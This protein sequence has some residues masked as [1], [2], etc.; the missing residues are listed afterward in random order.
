MLAGLVAVIVSI[1]GILFLFPRFLT[2]LISPSS[3]SYAFDLRY[4]EVINS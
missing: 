2:L 1:N 4:D 3:V